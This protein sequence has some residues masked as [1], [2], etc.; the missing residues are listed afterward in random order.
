MGAAVHR[1]RRKWAWEHLAQLVVASIAAGALLPLQVPMLR[2]WTPE[3]PMLLPQELAWSLAAVVGVAAAMFIAALPAYGRRLRI[4]GAGK[5]LGGPAGRP[6]QGRTSWG[7]HASFAVALAVV[8]AACSSSF[9]TRAW[10][11]WWTLPAAAPDQLSKLQ[12]VPGLA[13]SSTS[14]PQV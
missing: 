8:L 12:S 14:S 7:L 13:V 9:A 5:R 1:L 3:W 6:A 11:Q 2:A 4:R 10:R